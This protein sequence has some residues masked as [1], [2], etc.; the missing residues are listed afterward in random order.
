MNGKRLSGTGLATAL[1]LAL[2]PGLALA[3][4]PAASPVGT[5]F[6]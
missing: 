6:T 3:Q 5:A 2:L 4:E 1:V